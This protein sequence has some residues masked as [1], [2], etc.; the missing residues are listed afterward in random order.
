MSKTQKSQS[1]LLI[2]EKHLN[3]RIVKL[4]KRLDAVP[5]LS[6]QMQNL[7][8][9]QKE[10]EALKDKRIAEIRSLIEAFGATISAETPVS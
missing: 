10:I 4:Q 3:E 6:V 7:K 2:R 8:A 1:R 9:K 5:K